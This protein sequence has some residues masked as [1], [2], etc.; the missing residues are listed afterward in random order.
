MCRLLVAA[1]AAA[2]LLT[3]ALGVRPCRA[4]LFY[5]QE[6]GVDDA[7]GCPIPACATATLE[8]AE[9]AEVFGTLEI[10][11]TVSP[12]TLSFDLTLWNT[13]VKLVESVAGTEDNGVAE[14]EMSDVAYFAAELPATESFP[15]TFSLDFGATASV[16]GDQTQWSDAAAPVNGTPAFFSASDAQ[17]TGSCL[18]LAPGN[19]S[20][21]LSFGTNGFLLD[22]GDPVPAP[23]SL[24]HTLNLVLLPEPAEGPL[25]V[26][27]VLGLLALGRRRING[28]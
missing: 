15:D 13:P 24:R 9:A 5:V 26:S 12:P 28:R 27:G 16:D 4:D 14:L 10:D 25:L 2:L 17:V 8:L 22:V 3:P 21:S 19:A 7:V 20:C 1:G 6:G 18:V 23:R 11:T